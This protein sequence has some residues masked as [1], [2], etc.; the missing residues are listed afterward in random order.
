MPLRFSDRLDAAIQAKGNP[1][2]VGL[3]PRF[4]SLPK[5]IAD[6]AIREHGNTPRARAEA[7]LSFNKALLDALA[8]VV[9]V[10]KP[11][12]AFYEE[13]GADGIRAYSE[14]IRYAKS[15]GVL[16][17]SDAKR[18]D[19]GATAEAYARAHLSG[20]GA[21]FDADALT[22]NPYMGRD[23]L[24][25]YLKTGGGIFILVKTSNPGSGDLQ[26]LKLADGRI[27]R[28]HVAQ[29]V[30]E[31]GKNHRGACGL[32]D[33]GAVVGATYPDEARALRALMPDTIFLIPGYGAQGGSAADAAA[34]FRADGRG[35]IVNNSRGIIFAYKQDKERGE[36]HFADAAREAALKMA[37]ELRDALNSK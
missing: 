19:I 17:I 30:H 21:A 1:I 14:T 28:E 23:T 12:I 5:S 11:Q 25:P 33:V 18:G 4:E 20:A 3:D 22:V 32:S 13:L 2:C 34:G 31:L 9:P 10:C 6:A 37:R 15:K 16:V 24:E 27:V 7:F 8:D 36:A 35:A 29:M 26:D